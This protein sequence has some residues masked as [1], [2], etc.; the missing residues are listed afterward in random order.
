MHKIYVMINRDIHSKVVELSKKFPFVLITGPRQSGKSTL[1][2]MAFPDYTYISFSDLDVRNFA[3]EDPRGFI[4]TYPDK[5][6]IDEVQKEPTILSYLQTHTDNANKEGMYILTGSQ[7]ILLMSSVDESL[8]GRVGIL[9]LL[10]FSNAEMRNANI[11]KDNINEQ[12]FYGGYPR[13]YDKDI[14]PTDY[15]PDYI[16][17]Y[18]ERDIRNIKQIGDL[19]LFIKFIKLCAGRIGQLLNKA[20]LA[21]ECGITEPTVQ[22]WLSIL[23]QCYIVHLLK[24]DHKNFSKRLVKT[25]KLYFYDTGLLCSLL[26]ISSASQLATH[27]LRGELFE[28]MI[29]NELIK[30][31]LNNGR[32]PD[33]TFWRD[34]N[35]NEVDL[36][37]NKDNEI[38][39]YEIKSGATFNMNYFKG[40]NY[41]ANLSHADAEHKTVI[42]GGGNSMKTTDG[43]LLSWDRV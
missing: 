16:K 11:N 29:I 1:V 33:F 22:S 2:K 41:W 18:V 4:K 39:A 27:Y 9:N 8:A 7:N 30:K 40:L 28:N 17:T 26:E 19:S 21:N 13:I 15:Y 31:E 36:I 14:N 24:P 32:N 35:G 37:Q 6:I 20:S 10:P 25:P 38:F 43:E 34:S 23:E 3:K 42:F 12:I 5:V